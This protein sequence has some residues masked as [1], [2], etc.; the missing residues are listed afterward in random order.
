MEF[1]TYLKQIGKVSVLTLV[2]SCE[3]IITDSSTETE[4]TTFLNLYMDNQ[5]EGDYYIFDYPNGSESSYTSVLYQTNPIQRVF[6][7]S[8]DTYTFIYWGREM[9]YPIITNSTY[10]DG[11]GDGKQMIYIYPPHIGDTLS[12]IGCLDGICEEIEFIVK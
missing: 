4:N 11:N 10:S 3:E 9:T 5:K 1:I 12:I 2:L 7:F 6:W 8:E